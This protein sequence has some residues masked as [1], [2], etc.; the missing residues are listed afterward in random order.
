M[1]YHHKPKI[2]DIIYTDNKIESRRKTMQVTELKCIEVLIRSLVNK[3]DLDR[4][5]LSEF[6]RLSTFEGS[7]NNL[8]NLITIDDLLSNFK[9]IQP[10]SLE[11]FLHT[12]I[13]PGMFEE[14]I[15]IPDIDTKYFKNFN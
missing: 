6:D 12:G 13:V 14:K 1:K 8:F 15:Q 10:F 7:K 3:T 5:A 4:E 11:L 9:H 2:Y